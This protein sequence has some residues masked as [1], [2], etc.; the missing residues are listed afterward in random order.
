MSG[1]AM[2]GVGGPVTSQ[3]IG[4]GVTTGAAITGAAL[5]PG[6]LSV[7]SLAVPVAGAVAAVGL[8]IYAWMQRRNAQK[9]ATTYVVNEAEPL[10][11]Q[12]RDA[13]LAVPSPTDADKQAALSY[14]DAVWDQVVKEC[15][16][17]Q[18]GD[19]GHRCIEDRCPSGVTVNTA[20]GTLTCNGLWDWFSYYRTP[21]ERVAVATS[22]PAALLSNLRPGF[23]SVSGGN[24]MDAVVPALLAG[25]LVWAV[26]S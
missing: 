2:T 7:A 23:S 21:I 14:F 13:F 4:T 22:G 12:N 8:I 19:A 6:A 9:R 10:L 11:R 18:F 3:V 15:A 5:A 16:Q 25:A 26:A 24:V 20:I 1:Y 17:D